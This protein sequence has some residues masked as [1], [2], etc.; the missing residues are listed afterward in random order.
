MLSVRLSEF[1]EGGGEA[2]LVRYLQIEGKDSGL[3]QS[4]RFIDWF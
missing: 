1:D 3:Q 4:G 2:A